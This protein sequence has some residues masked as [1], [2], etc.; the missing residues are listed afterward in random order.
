MSWFKLPKFVFWT[1]AID[2]DKLLKVVAFVVRPIG[3]LVFCLMFEVFE[4]NPAVK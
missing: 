3:S 4:A 1:A 2:G